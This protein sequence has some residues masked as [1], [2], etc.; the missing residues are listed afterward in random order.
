M[1][2]QQAQEIA[3]VIRAELA[4]FCQRVE[5]AG[6]IRR[7]KETGIKDV[8]VVAIPR[9]VQG[10]APVDLFGEEFPATN[11]LYEWALKTRQVRWIKPGVSEIIDWEPKADGKYWRGILPNGAKL[12]LFITTPASFGLIYL[13]RTGPAELSEAVV[14]YAKQIGR[15]CREGSLWLGQVPL[16][17]P[18]EIDVFQA[19]GLAY[20]APEQRIGRG[21]V[22]AAREP[23]PST[24]TA[25]TGQG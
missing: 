11:L 7:G 2:L 5:I 15:P 1:D 8:E 10:E 16:E 17:T 24:S 21:Q 23:A 25:S 3:A 13:I 4:P 9:I 6:S 14:T 19:L 12:D 20:V 22:R 18:E